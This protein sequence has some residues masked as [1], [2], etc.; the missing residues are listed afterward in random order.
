[1]AALTLI[2]VLLKQ[3]MHLPTFGVDCRE[4]IAFISVMV[5][6]D[7]ATA[8]LSQNSITLLKIFSHSSMHIER[9]FQDTEKKQL[10][11]CRLYIYDSTITTCICMGIGTYL[12]TGSNKFN[13]HCSFFASHHLFYSK[14]LPRFEVASLDP[15]WNSAYWDKASGPITPMS[16]FV[17]GQNENQIL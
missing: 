1:M 12:H 2:S 13:S 17:N 15:P 9:A 6:A 3:Q 14:I 11:S 10:Y 16:Q 4:V 8:G 5:L 7:F